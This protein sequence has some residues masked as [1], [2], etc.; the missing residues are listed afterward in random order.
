MHKQRYSTNFPMPATP[1][2]TAKQTGID[3]E[4]LSSTAGLELEVK[5]IVERKDIN[6]N[7]KQ[8]LVLIA[9]GT[10]HQRA[11]KRIIEKVGTEYINP[12][13]IKRI[14]DSMSVIP[15]YLISSKENVIKYR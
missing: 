12:S 6:D 9:Q 14:E 15:D 7:Q 4:Q 8:K 10:Y 1:A 5:A 2:T 3:L 11:L 13:L